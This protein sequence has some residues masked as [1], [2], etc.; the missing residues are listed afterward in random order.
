MKYSLAVL[1]IVVM[2]MGC[3]GNAAKQA[4]ADVLRVNVGAEVADLDPQL[5]TGVPEHRINSAI[6]EGLADLDMATMQ[7]VP[8]AAASWDIS[9][10]GL[11]YTFHLRP[12]GKWSNGDPVT[13]ADFVYSYERILSP[14]FAAEYAYML[15]C[16]KNAKAFNEGKITDFAQVGAK[17]LDEH[18]LQLTLEHPTP[19]L[20]SMQMHQSWYPV[21][22]KS[23]EKFGGML[24]R[25][26]KWTQA[27][28]HVGNGP[29]RLAEWHPG[30]VIRVVKNEQYW[31]RDNVRIGEIA[32]Y[33]ISN[34]TTEERSF[35]SGAL[36]MTES[37]P[38]ML[39]PKYKQ[40][41]PAVL[42]VEPYL[43]TYFYRLNTT[44]PPL[45]DKR[46]RQALSL[47]IDRSVIT[48][49]ILK[50]G[51]RPAYALV[52][53]GMPGY[54]ATAKL[55]EDVAKAKALLAEA[56]YPDGKGLPEISVL[57]NTSE[58]HKT[59]AEAL[60][61]M[62][63][64]RLGINVT[65]TNQDWKVYLTTMQNLDYQVARGSWIADFMDPINYLELFLSTGGN[66]QTGWKNE[67]YD[68][69]INGAYAEPDAAKR[70]QMMQQAEVLLMDE[71]PCL[72]VYVYTFR[73]LQAERVKGFTP[74][75]L[76]YRRWKSLSLA[77][78]AA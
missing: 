64:E 43:G 42:H 67:E 32:F 34:L 2:G 33:P 24:D 51:E 49:S 4:P 58:M 52:P 47:A 45:D 65:L 59:I 14:K 39:V 27:G 46:V 66:N 41:N 50:S 11:V 76:G 9:P 13:A 31:D 56:G 77:A 23:V 29:Y 54:E 18:T 25:F 70:T 3:G 38:P 30:E 71:L 7:P 75:P 55:E 8:A 68:R 22:K 21:Q 6:F 72:P 12:E 36:D 20:L 16:L 35:R 73:Y 62:W 69:L 53:L 48:D 37:M 10:D 40:E 61:S 78:A 28:N 44:K 17:A 1:M 57:Y 63:K 74:N 19:Y 15:H 5:V 60:Q 26:T